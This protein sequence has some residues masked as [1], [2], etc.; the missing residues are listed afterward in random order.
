[1]SALDGRVTPW[2]N[3]LYASL[4]KVTQDIAP[5]VCF[6]SNAFVPAA[7]V[8]AFTE[9]HIQANL[10]GLNVLDIF[11]APA[12]VN[13]HTTLVT[14]HYLMY[15]P[16]CYIHLFLDSSGYTVKQIWQVLLPLLNQHRDMAHCQALLK[17]LRVASHGNPAHN[18][19]GQ[20]CPVPFCW[21]H[22]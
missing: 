14:A 15:V 9:E 12:A 16:S 5:M 20:A 10:Q 6:P 1:M 11:P 2:D 13:N 8:L 17:W 3:N 7:N 18:A 22:W 19:Q 21:F 4:G